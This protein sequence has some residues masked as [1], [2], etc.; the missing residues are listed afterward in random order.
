MTVNANF[1]GMSLFEV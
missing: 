1:K